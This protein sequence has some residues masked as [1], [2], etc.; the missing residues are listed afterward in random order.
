M[1]TPDDLVNIPMSVEVRA[2]FESF[3]AEC[4]TPAGQHLRAAAIELVR[5]KPMAHQTVQAID[6]L[7]N[8]LLW[9]DHAARGS[10]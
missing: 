7:R 1:H 4:T 2:A 8:A 5:A 9:C 3:S 10:R 6:A